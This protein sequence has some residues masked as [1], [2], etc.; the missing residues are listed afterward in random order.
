MACKNCR[1]PSS[2]AVYRHAGQRAI[3]IVESSSHLCDGP[4]WHTYAGFN[5]LRLPFGFLGKIVHKFIVLKQLRDIFSYRAVRIAEWADREELLDP[6]TGAAGNLL[7]GLFVHLINI[8]VYAENLAAVHAAQS[9]SFSA[10]VQF[11]L[12][13]AR[14]TFHIH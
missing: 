5:N 2:G 14:L 13:A 1:I 3:R 12:P 6:V 11:Y 7:P 4:Q 8:F 9:Y 10:D